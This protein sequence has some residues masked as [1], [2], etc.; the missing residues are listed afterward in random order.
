MRR[1]R[2]VHKV[3]KQVT[4]IVVVCT[5]KN[6]EVNLLPFAGG[7]EGEKKMNDEEKE[8]KN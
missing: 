1:K 4:R 2:Q 5:M 8:S 6:P 7:A 3:T